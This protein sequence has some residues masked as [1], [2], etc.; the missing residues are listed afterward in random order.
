VSQ[1]TAALPGVPIVDATLIDRYDAYYYSRDLLSL[2]VLRLKLGD[3]EGT[4]VYIDPAMSR[5]AA[6][7]TRRERIQRWLYH[8]L[9][10]LDFP[11]LYDRRPLWDLVVLTL[12]LGGTALSAIGAVLAA[13]R[14]T[15]RIT[16]RTA[17]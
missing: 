15:R 6:Q 11:W 1:V 5:I 12:C 8:G 2:P 16:S 17:Q 4:W 3:V 7:V 9:H 13:R 10:S 14:V